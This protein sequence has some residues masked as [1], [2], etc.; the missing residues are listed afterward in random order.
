M[1]NFYSALEIDQKRKF[2][3]TFEKQLEF[4]QDRNFKTKHCMAD[5][6][7]AIIYYRLLF[8]TWKK[9]YRDSLEAIE[10]A[11]DWVDFLEHDGVYATNA[12][13][14]IFEPNS[15]TND[16]II[17]FARRCM[18]NSLFVASAYGFKTFYHVTPSGYNDICEE[19]AVCSFAQKSSH[20][21]SQS[22]HLNFRTTAYPDYIL[23]DRIFRHDQCHV[24]YGFDI[25]HEISAI[26][27]NRSLL[28]NGFCCKRYLKEMLEVT[29]RAMAS[30]ADSFAC[31][32]MF[33]IH[34][35]TIYDSSQSFWLNHIL[36][37]FFC[38][39]C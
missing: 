26:E 21:I 25:G 4:H 33:C 31:P 34:Y 24:I 14:L 11:R 7:T 37:S 16:D 13:Y 27:Q 10:R 35:F 38:S 1:F 3:L 19:G 28:P 9:L 30:T 5:P 23:S 18:K 6:G 15:V 20:V 22:L 32:G 12:R 17:D 8:E 29:K 39:Y 2:G 36:R